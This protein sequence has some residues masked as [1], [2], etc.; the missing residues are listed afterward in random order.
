MNDKR[1][2]KLII[3]KNINFNY[4]NL[5]YKIILYKNVKHKYLEK[6]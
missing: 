5:I 1:N 6:V 4:F 3:K 2:K